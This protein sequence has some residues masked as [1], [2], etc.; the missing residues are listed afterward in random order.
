MSEIESGRR[1]FMLKTCAVMAG[2]LVGPTVIGTAVAEEHHEMMAGHGGSDGHIMDASIKGH[3]ATCE[4]WG[5]PR[6]VSKDG[7]TLTITGLGWCNSPKCP[8]YQ[9]MTSPDH[10]CHAWQKWIVLG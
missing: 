10:Q 1:S 9:G 4:S 6:R 7:K 2:A 5:G 3:C 8:G